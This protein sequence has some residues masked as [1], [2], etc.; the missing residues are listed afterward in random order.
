[1]DIVK[2][3][4]FG[5]LAVVFVCVVKQ[6]NKDI[7]AVVSVVSAVVVVALVCDNLY[8]VVYTLYNLSETAG[9]DG[10]SVACVV[11]V[12]GIGY[13]AEFANGICVDADCKN[14]GDKILLCGKVAIAM[15]VMPVVEGLFDLLRGFLL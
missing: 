12:V 7:A 14:L 2:V 10:D 5:V 15:S 1:M 8:D 4:L 9:V 6:K 13:I 3:A 11:K